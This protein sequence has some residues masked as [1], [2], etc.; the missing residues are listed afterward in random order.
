MTLA[1]GNHELRWL[2]RQFA[3]AEGRS[4][5]RDTLISTLA[6]SRGQRRHARD[7]ANHPMESTAEVLD[8]VDL[9][10]TQKGPL[11]AA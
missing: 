4:A 10:A 7:A 3:S 2:T 11:H 5:G 8:R 1:L 9:G 6:A